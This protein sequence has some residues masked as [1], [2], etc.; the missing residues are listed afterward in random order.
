MIKS[1]LPVR[2]PIDDWRFFY[3]E[4]VLDQTR[5][6]APVPVLNNAKLVSTIGSYTLGNG[7]AARMLW[8]LVNRKIP[9]LHQALSYRRQRI[10]RRWSG[11]ELVDMPFIEK[12][13]RL[14]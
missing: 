9:L 6:V 4:G 5:C 8:P 1:V 12:P 2:V 13:S 7:L 14:G 10:Q 11:V 3:R